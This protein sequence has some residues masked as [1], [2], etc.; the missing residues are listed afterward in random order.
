MSKEQETQEKHLACG[1]EAGRLTRILLCFQP[2]A[3][4]AQVLV[5]LNPHTRTDILSLG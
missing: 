5:S 1:M 4:A 2:I 3:E